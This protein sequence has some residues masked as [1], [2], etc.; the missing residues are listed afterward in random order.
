MHQQAPDSAVEDEADIR[1]NTPRRPVANHRAPP[2]E[3]E[4]GDLESVVADQVQRRGHDRAATRLRMQA[5]AD[6]GDPVPFEVEDR[7]C[8]RSHARRL[9]AP[10]WSSRVVDHWS[11]RRQSAQETP[12]RL[13][14]GSHPVESGTVVQRI[15]SGS[16]HCSTIAGRSPLRS[17]PERDVG[18]GIDE[19]RDRVG[20]GARRGQRGWI[21]VRH[22]LHPIQRCDE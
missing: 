6:L 4:P 21:R 12:R 1:R 10:Q 18:L 15:I 20:E 13:A 14:A 22:E 17:R 2:N 8:H 11:N 3:P 7:C 19:N 9:A 16:R 5:K